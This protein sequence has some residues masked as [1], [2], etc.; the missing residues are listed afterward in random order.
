MGAYCFP[1]KDLPHEVQSHYCMLLK[2]NKTSERAREAKFGRFPEELRCLS[3]NVT[4]I[5][6]LR[7]M[8]RRL[9]WSSVKLWGL[10]QDR[11]WSQTIPKD[12]SNLEKPWA[13]QE[14]LKCVCCVR[15]AYLLCGIVCVPTYPHLLTIGVLSIHPAIHPS[16]LS[17]F[18]TQWSYFTQLKVI[19]FGPTFIGLLLRTITIILELIHITYKCV[20]FI[21]FDY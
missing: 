9:G 12:C 13:F 17:C 21:R 20:I 2:G 3:P 1:N 18:K 15:C 4:V 14:Y 7:R 10:T 6:L 8:K 11:G 5:L 16:L 19:L